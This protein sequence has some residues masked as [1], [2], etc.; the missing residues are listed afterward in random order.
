MDG[1]RMSGDAVAGAAAGVSGKAAAGGA[2][3]AAVPGFGVMA[4][5]AGFADRGAR[6]EAAVEAM[7]ARGLRAHGE[8]AE[9][10]PG[11]AAQF[12]ALGAADE[13]SGLGLGRIGV[14]DGVPGGVPEGGAA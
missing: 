13:V 4:A 6:L 14:P 10:A 8:L 5:G 7:R 1:M 3:W 2:R 9:Y 11:V 12:G